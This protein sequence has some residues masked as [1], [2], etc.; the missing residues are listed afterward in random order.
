MYFAS[1]CTCVCAHNGHTIKLQHSGYSPYLTTFAVAK[2]SVILENDLADNEQITGRNQNHGLWNPEVQ[3]RIH[4]GS[5]TIPILRRINPIP[6][7]EISSK[8]ILIL[9]SHLCLGLPK[10]IFLAGVPVKILKALLP[11]ILTTW[12]AHLSLLDLITLII[13]GEWY[14]LW[15][16]SLWNLLHSP[17]SSLLG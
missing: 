6:H 14:K 7:I 1:I 3:C 17:F 2:E 5:P 4:K 9:S 12:P 8:S 13:L 16:S 11:S 15:S 10:C